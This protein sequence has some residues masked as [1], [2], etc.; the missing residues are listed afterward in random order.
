[1]VKINSKKYFFGLGKIN[2]LNS[3]RTREEFLMKLDFEILISKFKEKY[4]AI[5]P[6]FPEC[7]GSGDNEDEAISDLG[8]AITLHLGNTI[9]RTIADA[10]K[11]GLVR[12]MADDDDTD[13]KDDDS[14]SP[15]IAN[16][17]AQEKDGKIVFSGKM[18]IPI[19][20]LNKMDKK[21]MGSKAKKLLGIGTL[22]LGGY[23]SSSAN[24]LLPSLFDEMQT[25]Y[26]SEL[27]D[28][29]LLFGVPL[30]LN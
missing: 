29:A 20:W 28:D 15:F 19:E 6:D 23:S 4:R 8:D 18:P 16:N 30:S 7:V 12:Y 3:S 17:N 9:R 13:D 24:P 27:L 10:K 2:V 11:L 25:P 1:M 26:S 21:Q 22:G 5:C 14:L